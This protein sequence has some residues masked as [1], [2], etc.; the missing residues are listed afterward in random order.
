MYRVFRGV[1]GVL[2]VYMVYMWY[3]HVYTGGA[4][5]CTYG[6]AGVQRMYKGCMKGV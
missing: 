2:G 3:I 1:L 4:H 6:N 5:R